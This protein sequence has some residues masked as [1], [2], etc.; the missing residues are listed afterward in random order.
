VVPIVVLG[1]DHGQRPEEPP[2]PNRG[3]PTQLARV[4][5]PNVQLT[6]SEARQR[7]RPGESREQRGDREIRHGP[8]NAVEQDGGVL[9]EH[10][11]VEV[12][13][14]AIVVRSQVERKP[15]MLRNVIEK[16]R[17]KIS[18]DQRDDESDNEVRCGGHLTL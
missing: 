3:L 2:K 18:G 10:G 15:K 5:P 16:R 17:R 14:P 4:T 12:G 1:Q 7:T 9:R 13:S 11:V 8:Q 6:E